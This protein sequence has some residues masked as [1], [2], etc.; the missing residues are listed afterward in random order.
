MAMELIAEAMNEGARQSQACEV[1]GISSRTLQHWRVAGQEDRRQTVEKV[2]ANKLSEQEREAIIDVCNS[3]E[4]MSQPPKQIVPALADRGVYMAS[5][6]SFYRILRAAELLHHR[7]RAGKL[8]HD[9][10]A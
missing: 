3:P 2:P 9:Q 10:K 4:F 5:E 6:S 8:C 7:G 1:V